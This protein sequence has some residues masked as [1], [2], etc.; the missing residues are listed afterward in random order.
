M[1]TTGE[2]IEEDCTTYVNKI[3]QKAGKI[4]IF[5]RIISEIKIM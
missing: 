3:D 4:I 2:E 1:Q 5:L